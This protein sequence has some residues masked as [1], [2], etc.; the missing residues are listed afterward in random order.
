MIAYLNSKYGGATKTFL[1]ILD[2]FKNDP[3]LLL[4]QPDKNVKKLIQD[5]LDKYYKDSGQTF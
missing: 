1:E 5:T 4:H 3:H 2:N